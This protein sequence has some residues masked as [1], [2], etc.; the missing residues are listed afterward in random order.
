MSIW[1]R[2]RQA[3]GAGATTN[4]DEGYQQTGPYSMNSDAGVSVTDDRA[5]SLSAV[6]AC[7]RLLVQSGATLPLAL[8]QKTPDGR[9]Q[10]PMDDPVVRL[11]T[12]RPNLYMTAKQF[13]QAMWASR[14]QWGNAYARKMYNGSRLVGLMPLKP[15]YMAVERTARGLQYN[16]G[17]ESGTQTF[18]QD[19]ILHWKGM[20]F[21]GV[22]GVSPLAYMT[23]V[24]GVSV[25][26]D[27]KA[28]TSFAGRPMGVLKA[29]G[30]PNQEQREQLRSHYGN[31]G[32]DGT[33]D[34]SW[35]LLPGNM[36]YQSIGLPPD[37]LQLLESRNFNIA[38]V[39]RFYG[40]PTVMVD[41]NAGATA[42]W[43]ASY[44]QQ[45]LAFMQFTLRPY[46]EEFEDAVSTLFAPGEQQTRYAEHS[47][48]GF[49][50]ADSSTRASYYATMAQNG[51]MTRNE[52][53]QLE[54]LKPMPG[55]DDLT[56]QLNLTGVDDLG[57]HDVT[58]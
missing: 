17:T 45:V 11:L 37:D 49:L 57:E 56:V 44:E 53:R 3:F 41:G 26:A 14:V 51:L 5:M 4:P 7:V 9:E 58:E 13:R 25:A 21:D 6:F 12:H 46:L 54:N 40:V 35:W 34:G 15:A 47:V 52:I 10:L 27:R 32:T 29:E 36:S 50:R 39:C 19:E 22:V 28:A 38:E 1:P 8:Y 2:L 30:W 42:A 31:L 33:G 20:T 16:Y 24:L 43:P 48:E 23:H 18:R 55:G